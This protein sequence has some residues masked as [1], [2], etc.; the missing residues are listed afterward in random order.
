MNLKIDGH[1]FLFGGQDKKKVNT[2]FYV[3]NMRTFVW[4]KF[5]HLE[6]PKCGLHHI[7]IDM[8]EIKYFLGGV[9]FP[10]GISFNEVW[11]VSLRS[12]QTLMLDE[13]NLGVDMMQL[14]GI[15]WTK[16]KLYY[17]ILTK[18]RSRSHHKKCG[19]MCAQ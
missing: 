4:K 13:V 15:Q 11:A 3:L 14:G 2:D 7:M 12:H 18:E 17:Q 8:R 1:I 10:E 9:S 5:F 6:S 16:K 19:W